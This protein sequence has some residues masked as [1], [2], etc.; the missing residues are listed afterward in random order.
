[1]QILQCAKTKTHSAQQLWK[2]NPSH[3]FL[4]PR[5]GMIKQQ[6]HPQRRKIS[7]RISQPEAHIFHVQHNP[8][9]NR[10]PQPQN[11]SVKHSRDKVHTGVPA[12][13]DQR[14]AAASSRAA[15]KCQN[16][17]GNIFIA[18][19]NDRRV[20]RENTVNL[21]RKEID[22]EGSRHS[23]CNH[24]AVHCKHD[25]PHPVILCR[26][27]VLSHHGRPCRV[28]G[29]GHHIDRHI[30]FVGNAGKSGNRHAE[31]IDPG[32]DKHFGKLYRRVFN[33][34]GYAQLQQRQEHLFLRAEEL[35]NRK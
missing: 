8:E 27:D 10:Q 1:M 6:T 34:H 3:D 30:D 17:N 20:I 35:R 22:D 18:N 23:H 16:R 24:D 7:Q 28:H 9:Q 33:R 19:L 11:N 32:V 29:I 15:E 21:F 31:G 26:T 4:F 25:L 13:I 14:V 5:A 12:A 2:Y